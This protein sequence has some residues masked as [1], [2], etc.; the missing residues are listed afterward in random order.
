MNRTYSIFLKEELIIIKK[1]IIIEAQF[2]S[3]WI[4][5]KTSMKLP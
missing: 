3:T 4:Y 2:A 5:D 1:I